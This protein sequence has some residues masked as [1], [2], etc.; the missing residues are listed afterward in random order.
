MN[1]PR[2][3]PINPTVW[4]VSKYLVLPEMGYAGS[5][6]FYLMEEL[7]RSGHNVTIVT[8]DS[9]AKIDMPSFQR[10]YTHEFLCGISVWWLKTMKYKRANSFRRILSW[11]HFEWLFYRWSS[12]AESRPDVIIISSL[13]LLTIL[14]GIRLKRKLKCA[15]IFEVRD[16]W[17]LTLTAEGGVSEANPAIKLLAWIEK[18]G[19]LKSDAIV[20]TMPN[21]KKHVRSIGVSSENVYC[22]PMGYSEAALIQKLK[23]LPEGYQKQWLPEGKFLVGH[24][25][26]I[27]TTNALRVFLEAAV[28]LRDI[29]EIHF[30]L[31]GNGDLKEDFINEYGCFENITFGPA[32]DKAQVASVLEHF[33]LLYFSTLDS[34]VW[35][36]GQS[37]NKLVDY[38]LAGKPIVGSYSGFPSMIDEAACGELIPSDD[39]QS[40]TL[41]LKKYFELDRENRFEMGLRGRNWIVENRSYTR[42]ASEYSGII[43]RHMP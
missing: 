28:R 35:K 32:V 6:G 12:S 31:I 21:L 3:D 41:T 14:N 13:S 5:R 42:L 7:A 19:Y 2:P 37:L 18:L 15:L 22:I 10:K 27:G 38:M 24:V 26:S 40:L 20:G 29:Q 9:H 16:I 34:Q 4:Y 43:L 25:G 39:V 8:S 36:Y 33:D 23:P 17:P 30:V 1:Q 11:F